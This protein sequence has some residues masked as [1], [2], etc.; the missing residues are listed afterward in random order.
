MKKCV[1]FATY[2]LIL[3]KRTKKVEPFEPQVKKRPFSLRKYVILCGSNIYIFLSQIYIF[4]SQ[5]L[6]FGAKEHG[7]TLF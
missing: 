7:K 6:S 2:F 5:W 4:L 3:Y 1:F